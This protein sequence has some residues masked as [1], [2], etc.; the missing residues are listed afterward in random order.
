M[1]MTLHRQASAQFGHSSMIPAVQQQHLTLRGN[2]QRR[3]TAPESAIQSSSQQTSTTIVHLCK[4][5]CQPQLVRHVNSREPSLAALLLP[6][7]HPPAA[8]Q[9]MPH[10]AAHSPHPNPITAPTTTM[11]TITGLAAD[12]PADSSAVVAQPPTAAPA[13]VSGMGPLTVTRIA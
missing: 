11:T 6:E 8:N 9:T 7:H 1:M 2:R 4:A 10:L 3:G 12:S 13:T 5:A